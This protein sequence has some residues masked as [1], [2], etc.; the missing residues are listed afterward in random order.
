MTMLLVTV[1]T[2]A[3][4]EYESGGGLVTLS[5]EEQS[6]VLITQRSAKCLLCRRVVRTVPHIPIVM[7][8]IRRCK[9]ASEEAGKREGSEKHFSCRARKRR[10]LRQGSNA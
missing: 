6:V 10:S 5:V 4:E 9:I 8:L 2:E 3:L 1:Q 7:T